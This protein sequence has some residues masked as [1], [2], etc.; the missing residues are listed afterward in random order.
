MHVILKDSNEKRLD[1]LSREL[2]NTL[3]S[4][5][6]GADTPPAVVG[7]YAP[8][9]DRVAGESIRQIRITFPRNKALT[10]L[11]RTLSTALSAFGKERRYT[12]HL[13]VDVD[14]V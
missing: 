14:P 9:V 13:T 12:A 5:Y 6:S 4:A 2:R 8:I 3:L 7:P 11:K 1:F 10:A